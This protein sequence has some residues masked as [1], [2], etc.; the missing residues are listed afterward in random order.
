MSGA[1]IQLVSMGVQDTYIISDEG[2]SFFRM[3]FMRH[4]NFSQAPKFIKQMNENDTSI[5]IPVLGDI[6]NAL[7]FEG[8]DKALDMFY[9]ST[10][11]L[12]IGGQ[13]IDSQHFDYFADIWPNYLPDTYSKSRELNNKTSSANPSFVPIQ[14]FFCNHKAFLPLVALQNH[15]VEIKIKFDESVLSS[16]SE[17]DKTFSVYGNYIFL[18]K[19]ERESLVK[20][21]MDF[22]VTQVQRFEHPL[23][24]TDGY[25]SIDI[26]QFNHPVKSIFFGFSA[27][28]DDYKNDYF[29]FSNADMYLNGTPLFETMKPSFFHTIQNYYK[30]NYGI[31]EFDSTRQIPFY[32]RY[33]VYH[34]CLNASE[35][36]PSGT[37]N[38][39]RLDNAKMIIRGA[40]KGNLRPPD[41]YLSVYALNYNVL[42]IKD[43]LGGILFGN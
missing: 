19:D 4:T 37:C 28:D 14:F 18:D 17:S 32:T 42:R 10:V 40:Q 16:L 6:I 1:L 34:F 15:Q 24:T 13:K 12:Y 25:N 23:N 27:S 20:R 11:D 3:K 39:S 21:S 7:W 43:G 31:S 22:V 30:S 9:N 5:V 8:T 38:F 35:Y 2:H 36:N 26:S 33:Y 41:Q 29:T